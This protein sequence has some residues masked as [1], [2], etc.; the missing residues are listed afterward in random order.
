MSFRLALIWDKQSESELS[1]KII[2]MKTLI[3]SQD[4]ELKGKQVQLNLLKDNLNDIEA[5]IS[6]L[7]IK[8]L[9]I[10]N[11][12][13]LNTSNQLEDKKLSLVNFI[14]EAKGSNEEYSKI[15]NNYETLRTE[16]QNLQ[17]ELILLKDN[18][19]S[20]RSTIQ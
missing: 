19:T 8:N 12:L 14:E 2:D 3:A 10:R 20:E 18:K 13:F 7:N 15:L 17:E 16:K 9:K 4:Q 5:S 11:N 6:K 1:N